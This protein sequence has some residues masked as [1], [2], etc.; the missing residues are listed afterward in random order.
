[1]V[2][3]TYLYREEKLLCGGKQPNMVATALDVPFSEWWDR[4]AYIINS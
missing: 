1:V 2:L 4:R 3:S